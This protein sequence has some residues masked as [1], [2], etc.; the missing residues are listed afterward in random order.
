MLNRA[1]QR[2]KAISRYIYWRQSIEPSQEISY[3]ELFLQRLRRLG[4]EDTF[5]PVG[6]AANH[7]LLYLITRAIMDLGASSVLEFGAGQSTLL[8]DTLA[9]KHEH[10]AVRSIEHDQVWAEKIRRQV[11]HEVRTLELA[12]LSVAGKD[13]QYYDTSGIAAAGDQFDLVIVDGPP[14]YDVARRYNRVGFI[15]AIEHHLQD[16]FL[17]VI[18]DA[19]RTGERFCVAECQ[20]SL[21]RGGINFVEGTI[22]GTKVQHVF[23][24]GAYANAGIV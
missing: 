3:R 11:S 4:I 6:A 10:L 1:L 14:P 17:I 20:R 16:N 13:I 19:E 2:A 21:T 23:A 5:D 15:R 9:A 22:R 24:G 12:P 18:D 7:G 8:L